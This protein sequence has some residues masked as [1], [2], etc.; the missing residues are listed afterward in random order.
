MEGKNTTLED[1]PQLLV[2]AGPNGSG[3]STIGKSRQ[4]PGVYINA[5]DIKEH[6][7][8]TDL[9]AAQEA[10]KIREQCLRKKLDLTFET[11]LST[12]RNLKFI[13]KAKQAGYHIE[14][15]FVLTAD[16]ELNVLRIRSR[17]M[18]GGHSVPKNKIRSRY[19]KSLSNLQ[20]LIAL[21]DECYVFDNTGNPSLIF[22]WNGLQESIIENDDWTREKIMA[23][24]KAANSTGYINKGIFKESNTQK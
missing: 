4:K 11:V 18:R 6:R 16:A 5:D 13:G 10:E 15:V 14:A 8:C 24:V 20:K 2:F 1:K 23:L 21:C 19:G 3:K 9:E 17:V 7:R 12:D 22:V